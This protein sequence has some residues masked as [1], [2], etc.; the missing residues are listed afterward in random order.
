MG[1]LHGRKRK[2]VLWP[3][4]MFWSCFLTHEHVEPLTL[5]SCEIWYHLLCHRDLSTWGAPLICPTPVCH[6]YD[7]LV[8]AKKGQKKETILLKKHLHNFN[9]MLP[10]NYFEPRCSVSVH[11]PK[12]LSWISMTSGSGIQISN[13]LNFHDHNNYKRCMIQKVSNITSLKWLRQ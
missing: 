8:T 2:L 9:I 3:V 13:S 5:I 7:F 1:H 10:N 12:K 6:C 11:D 4:P